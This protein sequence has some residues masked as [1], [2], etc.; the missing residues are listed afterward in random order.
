MKSV[1]G[2]VVKFWPVIEIESAFAACEN[3]S[4]ANIAVAVALE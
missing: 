4:K 1:A 3:V 2:S